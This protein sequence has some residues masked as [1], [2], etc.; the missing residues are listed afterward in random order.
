M[1]SVHRGA[2]VDSIQRLFDRGT[3][4]SLGERQ[5][6]DRFLARA[7]QSAF[8]AIVGRHEI[9]TMVGAEL[10]RLPQRLRAPLIL[11][12]LEGRTHEQAALELR[13]PV[14]T[15]SVADRSPLNPLLSLKE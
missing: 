15:V 4:A 10:N 5:L 7:D 3:V 9:R 13:C 6:L 1:S 11:C 12:D 8:E 14:G 2:V